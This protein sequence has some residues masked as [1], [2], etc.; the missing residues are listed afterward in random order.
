M[1]ADAG[2][3]NARAARS[4][5]AAHIVVL[6]HR[7]LALPGNHCAWRVALDRVC[8]TAGLGWRFCRLARL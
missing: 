5:I 2:A 7:D 4:M 6:E 1:A 8:L 3:A